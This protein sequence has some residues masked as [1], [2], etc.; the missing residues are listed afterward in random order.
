MSCD[1]ARQ[2]VQIPGL[3]IFPFARIKLDLSG[4]KF[5]VTQKP[6]F[7][8]SEKLCQAYGLKQREKHTA[9]EACET[10]LTKTLFNNAKRISLWTNTFSFP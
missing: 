2:G 5:L 4:N 8:L 10:K 3:G 6:V 1:M 7:L 9:A